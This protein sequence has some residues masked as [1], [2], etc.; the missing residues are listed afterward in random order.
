MEK[1]VTVV[2]PESLRDKLKGMRRYVREPLWVV[3]QRFVICHE[4]DRKNFEEQV[5]L[6]IKKEESIGWCHVPKRIM[7]I[8]KYEGIDPYNVTWYWN[9]ETNKVR[10][11]E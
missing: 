6:I 10:V 9:M 4:Y 7:R 5:K 1:R 3:I 11:V 2:L 8:A